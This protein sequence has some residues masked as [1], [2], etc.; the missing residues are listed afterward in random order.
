[1]KGYYREP[2]KTHEVLSDDGWLST[3][4][5]GRID[6][7]G[8]LHVVG[9]VK[10]LIIRSGFNVYPPEVEA[11]LNDHPEVVQSAVIGRERDGNEDVLAFVE[12]TGAGIDPAALGAFVADALSAYKRPSAIFVVDSLPAAA[13][14]KILKHKLLDTFAEQI[15]AHD[16]QHD[17]KGH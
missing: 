4:D 12:A 13:T 7:A 9:R 6:D 3:G 5:L 14:G 15:S 1:M 17:P 2:E 10:E 16:A 8:R 11:A